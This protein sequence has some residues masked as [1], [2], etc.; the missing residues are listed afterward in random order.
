MSDSAPPML[1]VVSKA[2]RMSPFGGKAFRCADAPVAL[3]PPTATVRVP[4]PRAS[5]SGC[6]AAFVSDE[7]DPDDV[8]GAA[9]DTLGAVVSE[10]AKV[11]PNVGTTAK[12][13]APTQIK[14]AARI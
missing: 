11:A 3:A 5:P 13:S 7:V 1:P 12:P 10:A 6:G 9:A 8:V 14:H 2:N 4:A